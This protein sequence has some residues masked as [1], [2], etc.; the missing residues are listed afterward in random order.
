MSPKRERIRVYEHGKF[1]YRSR[2]QAEELK[3]AGIAS[4]KG[5]IDGEPAMTLHTQFF[6][7]KKTGRTF[8]GEALGFAGM[9][10]CRQ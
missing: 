8:G 4:Y 3:D 2:E 6:W 5:E 10:L 9:A 7:R 1:K